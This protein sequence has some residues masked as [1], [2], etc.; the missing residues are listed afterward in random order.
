MASRKTDYVSEA[1]AVSSAEKGI[2]GS[3]EQ[4]PASAEPE[5]AFD[6]LKT[7]EETKIRYYSWKFRGENIMTDISTNHRKVHYRSAYA[8][9][10][11]IFYREAGDALHPTLLLLHGFPTSSHMFRNL[12]PQLQIASTLSRL[13]SQALASRTRRT[14]HSSNTL[15]IISRR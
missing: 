3:S 7:S 12:I 13:T 11:N 4:Y 10:V 2:A 9:G 8:N 6:E 15:S 5:R 1:L 14:G